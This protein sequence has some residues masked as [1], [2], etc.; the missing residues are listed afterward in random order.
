MLKVIYKY[1]WNGNQK[2]WYYYAPV[3]NLQFIPYDI[4]SKPIFTNDICVQST[5]YLTPDP[6]ML[7]SQS[8]RSP[9]GPQGKNIND[10]PNNVQT[11][12]HDY[13]Y[14][15]LSLRQILMQQ[16]TSVYFI[17]GRAQY[18][19]WK[20]FKIYCDIHMAHH[21][22]SVNCSSRMRY[23]STNKIHLRPGYGRLILPINFHGM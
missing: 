13:C 10:F 8:Q 11:Y 12:D 22:N 16:R 7:P 15:H 1:K 17:S 18:I 2:Q 9:A 21:R 23:V 3:I 19:F 5:N 6:S 4:R 14:V 20:N